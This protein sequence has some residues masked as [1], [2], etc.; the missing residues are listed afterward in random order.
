M[1]S[2]QFHRCKYEEYVNTELYKAFKPIFFSMK[3][4][5]LYFS[6]DYE[7]DAQGAG[8][9]WKRKYT[10]S[11]IY[12]FLVLIGMILNFVRMFGM[13]LSVETQLT[14][15]VFFGWKVLCIMNAVSCFI[16]CTRY[17]AIP[18]FFLEW[19]RACPVMRENCLKRFKK[20]VIVLN[21]LC[22]IVTFLNLSF[23]I[24]NILTSTSFD[25]Y[26]FPMGRN[27]YGSLAMKIFGIVVHFYFSAAWVFPVALSYL[28]CHILRNEFKFLG[29]EIEE[30]TDF[31][32]KSLS[33][34]L[35]NYR[36]Q[37]IKYTAMVG[38]AN[39]FLTYHLAASCLVNMVSFS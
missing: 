33:T 35:E 3:I 2:P 23:G 11:M 10:P 37:H 16:G 13:L 17:H 21:V 18:E 6:R 34:N 30:S 38:R 5:G 8:I 12:S 25:H 29:K 28:V 32:R 20:L 31:K 15:T 39:D 27:D 7:V 24:Y 26:L 1:E 19:D 36:W 9:P 22:I 4:F 14:I